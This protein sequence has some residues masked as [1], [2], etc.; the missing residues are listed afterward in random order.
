MSTKEIFNWSFFTATQLT[1]LC[2]AL[3]IEYE[4]KRRGVS[5]TTRYISALET[6]EPELLLCTIVN[7]VCPGLLKNKK[8]SKKSKKT[9]K[10]KKPRRTNVPSDEEEEEE[11][12]EEEEEEEVVQDLKSLQLVVRN[13]SEDE[14]EDEYNEG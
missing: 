5:N 14:D 4:P 8:K 7:L 2:N 9:E 10:P 1:D 6:V 13:A 3:H 11:K 12:E